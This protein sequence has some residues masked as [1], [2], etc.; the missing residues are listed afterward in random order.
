MGALARLRRNETMLAWATACLLVCLGILCGWLSGFRFP[1]SPPNDH[2][3]FLSLATPFDPDLA[4]SF[5][6]AVCGFLIIAQGGGGSLGWALLLGGC[7]AWMAGPLGESIPYNQSGAI[8]V[9]T[10]GSVALVDVL[11]GAYL[12]I[13]ATVPLWLPAGRLVGLVPRLLVTCT[14]LYL[15][16]H[17]IR[18][19]LGLDALAVSTNFLP[20]ATVLLCTGLLLVRC[21]RASGALRFRFAVMASVYPLAMARMDFGWYVPLPDLADVVFSYSTSLAWGAALVWFVTRDRMWLLGRPARRITITVLLCTALIVLV[22][23][24]AAAL[25]VVMSADDGAGALVMTVAALLAGLVVRPVIDRTAR[26]V[27]RFFYGQGALPHE[28]VRGLAER[29]SR[30]PGPDQVPDALSRSVVDDLGLPAA[31]IAVTTRSG[32][33]ALARAG[34]GTPAFSVP[35]RYQ[36]QVIGHLRV[37]PRAGDADLDD[38]DR[39]VLSILADQGA[40]AVAG[41]RL[42]Q[43]LQAARERLVLAREAERRRLHRD[44]HDGLGPLLAATRLGLDNLAAAEPRLAP[45]LERSAAHLMDAVDEIRR[46]THDMTPAVLAER[47]LADAMGD[48]A[49]RLGTCGPEITLHLLP[50]PLP[51]LPVAIE[52]AV[53]RIAAEALTN[54]IRHSTAVHAKIAVVAAP[55]TVTLTVTDDGAGPF[56][57][58][59]PSSQGASGLGLD[60]MRERAEE[61]GGVFALSGTLAGTTVQVRFDI[62]RL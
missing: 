12:T 14:F 22:A 16:S 10:I 2:D 36:G 55:G 50:D 21:R 61:L 7:A 11:Q 27:D 56:H 58:G 31:E 13:L 37:A 18:W 15:A 5:A 40:P 34:A 9:R 35:M 6:C 23:A 51:A 26:A 3:A 48:L 46:I 28:A 39:Y 42:R 47:G 25:A 33:R 38:R 20:R 49:Q 29:L 57:Q 60:S 62:S 54:T 43:D 30:V 53:Y 19:A 44:L 32:E 8:S 52:V 45:V 1:M 41:L 24:G 59:G 17:N 4:A